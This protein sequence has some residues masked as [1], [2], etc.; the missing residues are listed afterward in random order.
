MKRFFVSMIA[1]LMIFT[2]MPK[3]EAKAGIIL[4]PVAVGIVLIVLGAVYHDG[5]LL[6]LDED[7]TN[8]VMASELASKYGK[9]TSN[10]AV[11]N[12]LAELIV[13]KTPSNLV[14]RTEIALT[15]DEIY[16]ALGAA[17]ANEALVEALKADLM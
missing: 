5:L 1:A 17:A 10:P 9:L 6:I 2:A 16:G 3:K 14:E 15:E 4:A 8:S 12:D 7:N 13:S 11:F